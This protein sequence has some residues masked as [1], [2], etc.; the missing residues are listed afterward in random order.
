MAIYTAHSVNVHPDGAGDAVLIGGITQ[1][2]ADIGTE[3]TSE[4]V[5]GS[6]YALNTTIKSVKPKFSFSTRDITK[7]I[8]TCGLVGL[9]I[10]GTTNPGV[11]MFSAQMLNGVIRSGSTHRKVRM[12]TGRLVIRKI[13]VSHQED[14]QADLEAVSLWDG[15]NL[16]FVPTGSLALPGT[17]A[18][19]GRFTLA[20]VSVGG[21]AIPGVQS[22]DI[23]F[24]ITLDM[25]GG[26][27]NVFDTDMLLSK[28]Q[29]IITL[30]TMH[31]DLFAVSGGVPLLGLTGTQAN[32]IIKLRKR[33]TGA[34]P[35]VANAT[36]E[37]ISIT[38]AGILSIEKAFSASGF[39]RG[40]IDYKL[41]TRFDGTNVPLVFSTTATLP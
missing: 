18:D 5:A 17:P 41:T 33:L 13:S 6:P 32:T 1:M 27:S 22:L 3:I 9:N 14:A 15:T 29:P 31:T 25:F 26:D 37:H 28:I 11:E 19:P 10:L 34:S 39:K 23:D 24:G 35:F 7:S 8:A 40:E 38:T 16:P 20:S 12:S 2:D 30:K 36:A 4:E 21:V